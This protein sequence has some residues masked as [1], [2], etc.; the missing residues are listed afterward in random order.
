MVQTSALALAAPGA[1][2]ATQ[3]A[4][5]S[6]QDLGA[7]YSPSCREELDG[8]IGCVKLFLQ[9]QSQHGLQ[10]TP[11]SSEHDHC[12]PTR[13]LYMRCMKY[14]ARHPYSGRQLS[15]LEGGSRHQPP[16]CE[17]ELTLHGNCV[18]LHLERSQKKGDEKYF[19]QGGEDKCSLTRNSYFKCVKGVLAGLSDRWAE[20]LPSQTIADRPGGWPKGYTDVNR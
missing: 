6:E 9:E 13:D 12:R 3:R 11:G 14:R 16:P 7:I 1:A 15:M 2:A 5:E 20:P 17:M 8:H 19:T 18:A 10:F 4:E